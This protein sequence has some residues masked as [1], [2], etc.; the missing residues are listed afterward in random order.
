MKDNMANANQKSMVTDLT[1]GGVFSNLVR[2]A[3]PFMLSNLLQMLYSMIDMI[4]VGQYVGSTGLSAVTISSQIIMLMTTIA[5]GFA[6]A[7]QVL[8]SQQ[9]GSKDSEGRKNTIGTLFSTLLIM[10][11]VMTVV[12]LTLYVPMLRLLQVPQESFSQAADYMLVCSG[13]IVFTYGYNSISA[14]LRG[15]GDGKRPLVFIGIASLIN[16]ALDL[17]FVGPMGLQA[18]GA[19]WATIIAQAVSFLISIVYLY[20]E[21]EAVGFDFHLSSFRIHKNILSILLRLGLPAAL[22]HSAISI[23]MLFINGFINVYGLAASAAF[24]VGRRVEM[25]PTTLTMSVSMAVSAMVGQNMAAGEVK[26]SKQTVYYALCVNLSVTLVAFVCFALWPRGVFAIFTQDESVLELSKLL[27]TTIL[28]GMP[29]FPIMQAFNPFIQGIGNA[30]LSLIIGLMD[31]VVAR[32]G[33]CLL[34]EQVLHMGM[35]GVLL[36]Y[37]LAT[38]VTAIPAMVYFLSGIWKKRKLL[39]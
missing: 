8:I 28:I 3:V 1:T 15:M 10:A 4:V 36:G 19:A 2:L 9:V 5:T 27:M 26:R 38:Y 32:I 25:L 31:G 12:G 17:L 20:R 33:L 34:F 7:G 35:F 18:A 11:A 29:A 23:S 30:R 37:T 21:R 39:V 16:V 13:G 6:S 14:I 24:G 22:Q